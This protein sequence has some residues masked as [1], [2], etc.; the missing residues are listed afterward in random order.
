MAHFNLYLPDDLNREIRKQAQSHGKSISSYLTEIIKSQILH[1]KWSKDFFSDVV[2]GWK[3]EFPKIETL[4]PE[5][6]DDL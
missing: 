6:R 1:E 3:G 4:L 5:E 2:G